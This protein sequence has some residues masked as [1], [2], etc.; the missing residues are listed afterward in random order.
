MTKGSTVANRNLPRLPTITVNEIR[1]ISE[2][3]H[4]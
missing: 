1:P 3:C 4:I 2:M